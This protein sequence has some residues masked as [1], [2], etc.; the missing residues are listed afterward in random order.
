MSNLT[1]D[2]RA[3]SV[4][5]RI[6]LVEDIWDSIAAE[7]PDAV[8][9]TSAQRKELRRRIAAHDAD[10]GSAVPWDTVRTELFQQTH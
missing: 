1:P 10:P 2:F 8:D 4:A 3:L 9:L 6:Q 5:E 7:G